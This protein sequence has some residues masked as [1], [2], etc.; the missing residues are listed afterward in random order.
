[1]RRADL[2]S[3]HRS[4]EGAELGA[5]KSIDWASTTIDTITIENSK[6]VRLVA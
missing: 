2:R 4:I 1:M 3:L 6:P 5:L